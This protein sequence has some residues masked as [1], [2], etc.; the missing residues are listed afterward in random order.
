MLKAQLLKYP[1]DR[2]ISRAVEGRIDYPD[3]VSHLLYHLGMDDE[4]FKLCHIFIIDLTAYHIVKALCLCLV[5]VHGLSFRDADFIYF[6]YY[7]LI[8]GY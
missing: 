7:L 5:K 1:A 3:I 2:H 4:L 8:P 6:I